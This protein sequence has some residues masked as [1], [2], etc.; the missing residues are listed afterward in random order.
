MLLV[1]TKF[2]QYVLN[3]QWKKNLKALSKAEI[4]VFCSLILSIVLLIAFDLY[5]DVVSQA[6]ASHI[7]LDFFFGLGAST[8]LF[9]TW[10]HMG[11]TRDNHVHTIATAKDDAAHWKLEAEAIQKGIADEIERQI[12]DWA[13]TPSEKEVA[14]LLLKGLSLKE[15]STVRNTAERTVR[16]HTLAI[17]AKA[18]VTGR[19]E[20]SAFFLEEFLDRQ[21][22]IAVISPRL[23]T[24][25]EKN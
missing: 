25:K 3:G 17:Y 10:L 5:S 1:N 22:S 20:L 13:L 8:G 14:F 9:L 15:I 18:G 19:A 21:G 23:K 16:H 11:K 7:A 2:D 12:N 24:Q 6:S 4:V